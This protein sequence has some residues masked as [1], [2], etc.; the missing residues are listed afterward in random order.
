MRKSRFAESQIVAALKQVEA[1]S[2]VRN[3]CRELGIS[4]TTYYVW[5]SNS[6]GGAWKLRTCSG[7]A[8]LKPSTQS[9]SGCTSNLR[10]RI[11]R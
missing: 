9:S 7:C 10:W 4:E 5:K 1:G 6:G 3:V 8:A 2:W 11:M